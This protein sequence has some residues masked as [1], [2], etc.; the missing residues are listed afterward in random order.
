MRVLHVAGL[1]RQIFA[2]LIPP[3]I[4]DRREGSPRA[5]P[6]FW[7]SAERN[8]TQQNVKSFFITPCQ[9]SPIPASKVATHER[10]RSKN[11]VLM[12]LGAESVLIYIALSTLALAFPW[13]AAAF[14]NSI[15]S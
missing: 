2:R 15:P 11:R 1:R 4:F 14:R 5:S 10:H 9:E 12:G 3:I 6:Y 7:H 8:R 13:P